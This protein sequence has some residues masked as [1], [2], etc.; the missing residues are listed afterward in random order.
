VG[1]GFQLALSADF[2]LLCTDAQLRLSEVAL[3]AI[4]DMTG[5]APLVRTVGYSRALELCVSAR[6]IGAEQAAALG[7]ATRV[8]ALGQLDETL[9]ELVASALQHPAHA[10]RAVKAALLDASARTMAEQAAVERR[11]QA[12]VILG[13]AEADVTSD[14]LSDSTL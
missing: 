10:V 9:A 1:A 2:R 8:A 13:E 14:W 6:P 12:P 11:L 5:T 7:L 3:G 4:P